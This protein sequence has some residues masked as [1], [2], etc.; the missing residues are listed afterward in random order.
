[1]DNGVQIDIELRA[2]RKLKNYFINLF[3]LVICL[4]L[5]GYIWPSAIYLM[6]Y[7]VKGQ[8]K[9]W[10]NLLGLFSKVWAQLMTVHL[11]TELCLRFC[12]IFIGHQVQN[13]II[14]FSWGKFYR[15]YG[16]GH[17]YHWNHGHIIVTCPLLSPVIMTGWAKLKL[18]WVKRAWL[19]DTTALASKTDK[20]EIVKMVIESKAEYWHL[21]VH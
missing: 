20:F 15:W 16:W 4:L 10:L 6:N 9:S 8:Q 21:L 1:M 2:F 14:S 5:V 7:E 12:A 19:L 18:M 3:V 11:W 13:I 17:P